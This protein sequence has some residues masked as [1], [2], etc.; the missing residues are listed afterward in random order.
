MRA[1][2]A[3]HSSRRAARI[4]TSVPLTAISA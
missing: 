4:V 3:A 1:T 2:I